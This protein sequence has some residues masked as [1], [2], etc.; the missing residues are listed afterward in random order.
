[1]D[2]WIAGLMDCCKSKSYAEI[3]MWGKSEMSILKIFLK[4]IAYGFS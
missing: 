3:T 2:Y 1:M 4:S